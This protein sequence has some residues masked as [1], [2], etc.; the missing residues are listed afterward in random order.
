MLYDVDNHVVDYA[1]V[2]KISSKKIARL[3]RCLDFEPWAGLNPYMGTQSVRVRAIIFKT[4]YYASF[5][6]YMLYL[7]AL[8][9]FNLTYKVLYKITL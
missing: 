5:R 8:I 1:S 6:S 4:N 3:H 7:V 2:R 9:S